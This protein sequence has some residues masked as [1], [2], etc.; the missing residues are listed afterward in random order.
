MKVC[1]Y[2]LMLLYE[3]DYFNQ[4]D[5]KLSIDEI[6]ERSEGGLI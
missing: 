4:V 5:V 6:I 3:Y 1:E 2:L